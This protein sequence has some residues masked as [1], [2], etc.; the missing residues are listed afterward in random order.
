MGL[1]KFACDTTC[2]VPAP[3]N[4]ADFYDYLWWPRFILL[5]GS[6][7]LQILVVRKWSASLKVE[8]KTCIR[9]V[10]AIFIIGLLFVSIW[11]MNLPYNF[12][13]LFVSW[14]GVI[15]LY[16]SAAYFLIQSSNVIQSFKIGLELFLA[17]FL[18][19][20]FVFFLV[21]IPVGIWAIYR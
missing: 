2:L 21:I 13:Q 18:G 10:G 5:I 16:T 15:L 17:G 6:A 9:F 3:A 1:G 8:K 7:I 19:Y 4:A 20:W 14:F 11:M 12:A